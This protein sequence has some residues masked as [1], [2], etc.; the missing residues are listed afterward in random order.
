[1]QMNSDSLLKF[2][3]DAVK[4]MTHRKFDIIGVYLRGSVSLAES[5][6][7]GGA[8][9]I[10]LVFIHN[11]RPQ[12]SRE[13]LRLTDDVHLDVAH[14]DQK[15]YLDRRALRVDPWMGPSLFNAKVLYD[16]QHF[17]DFT[18]AS[19]R[20]LFDRSEY[21]IQRA[22]TLAE[23]A[24][25]AWLN[26]EKSSTTQE[27]QFLGVYLETIDLAANAVARLTGE[28]LTDRRF[29]TEFANCARRLNRSGMVVGLLGLLGAPQV[30]LETLH[31]WTSA[32]DLSFRVLDQEVRPLNLHLDRR[33]YYLHTF[34]TLLTSENPKNMLWP[35][36]Q[37]WSQIAAAAPDERAIFQPWVE[38]CH[39]LGLLGAGVADRIAGLDAYLE[40][41]EDVIDAWA[42]D[43]GV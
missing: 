41:V 19:V 37:T 18:L 25:Q 15:D 38:A 42:D 36:L 28:P 33:N 14:H 10:D 13:I 35:L 8:T 2:A 40:Q 6:L 27:V 9:D 31:N 3:N 11:E 34:V 29:V 20:G 22:R 26:L 21:V 23:R 4:K 1:M 24:R 32:W 43:Q 12:I 5:P 7:L 39:H 30:D 16:P 17:I